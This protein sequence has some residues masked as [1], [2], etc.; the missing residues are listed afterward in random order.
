VLYVIN[1]LPSPVHEQSELTEP[2]VG[3]ASSIAEVKDAL[4]VCFDQA[5]PD[6]FPASDPF[7]TNRADRAP[8]G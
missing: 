3:S 5:Q 7:T 1:F 6:S 8:S 2:K 4:G